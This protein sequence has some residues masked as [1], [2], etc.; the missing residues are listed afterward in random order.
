MQ[1]MISETADIVRELSRS[2][3]T[4]FQLF[5]ISPCQKWVRLD[6]VRVF[7]R[8][9]HYWRG[10]VVVVGGLGAGGR[11]CSHRP[12]VSHFSAGIVSGNPLSANVC[13]CVH[14]TYY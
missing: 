14:K 11:V 13:V 3:E 12:P 7:A 8:R 9:S 2:G 1:Q 10:A 6:R 5:I 4:Y